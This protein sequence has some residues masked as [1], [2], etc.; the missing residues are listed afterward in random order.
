MRDLAKRIE[1]AAVAEESV[2]RVVRTHPDAK[3][4]MKVTPTTPA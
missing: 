1:E 4:P 3:P 2:F